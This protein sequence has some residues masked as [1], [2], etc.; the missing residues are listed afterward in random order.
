MLY[1]KGLFQSYSFAVPV[2]AIGNLSTGGTGKTPQTEYLIRLLSD[3]YR[4]V[5]L[6]RGYKRKS[7]GF[8]LGS[9]TSDAN[10]LG[11]EPFQFYQKF[12]QIRVAVDADRKNGIEQLLD[13]S[14][15][16]EIILMDDAYQ[17]RR[18]K[19]GLYILLTAYGD[20][21]AD[22]FVLPAGNLREGRSGAGR[23]SAIIVTKCPPQ[24]SENVKADIVKKLKPKISQK[25]YFTC[26]EYDNAVY[27]DVRQ[28][29]SAEVINT[30]K[31]LVA[32]IAKPR[33]FF[34]HL[35]QPG[36]EALAYDDHHDFT[37]TELAHLER[38]ALEKI[39]VT[40]EKDYVRLRGKLPANRLFYLPIKSRFLADA[41]N[42]D[43]TILDY[44]GK[45]TG[46]R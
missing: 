24:L 36:D 9:T 6:S 17:H 43:K 35:K 39:I 40:T 16:P 26:I 12:P 15:K 23:A 5:T 22:D 4:V 2:I 11:D 44:V 25:V 14:P 3:Q 1:N 42:F 32:G 7:E 20:I 46:N 21:Y 8:V 10:I 34:E 29:D 41:D 13:L 38:L 45:S 30:P 28:I 31:V 19:A 33:P 18:V 37:E 27:S